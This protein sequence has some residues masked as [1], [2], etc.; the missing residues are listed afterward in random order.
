MTQTT[1]EAPDTAYPAWRYH[2]TL[3]A[4]IVETA[5]EDEALG[6]GWYNHPGKARVSGEEVP[7]HPAHPDV[8]PTPD[9]EEPVR[10]S[11]KKSRE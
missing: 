3:P 4:H 1:R 8:D 6:E 7:P 2:A 11:R 5:E 10:T 9:G